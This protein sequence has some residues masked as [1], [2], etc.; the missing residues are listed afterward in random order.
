L[1]GEHEVSA[2]THGALDIT[3]REAVHRILA[4]VKPE[5]IFNCAVLQ[6]DDCERDAAKAEAVNTRG[7]QHLAE[8]AKIIGAGMVHFSTQYAF[9]GEPARREPYT[10]QDEPR[11]INVY[12]KTKVAGEKAVLAACPQ[13]YIVRTSWVYGSGKNSFLCSVHDD[14]KAGRKVRA[15]DDIWSSTTYVEDLIDR[16]LEIIR[17][18]RYGTYHV[19]NEGVCTYY[20]FA[21]DAG[22]LAGLSR[23]QVDSLIEITHEREMRRIAA[24]P[25]YTPMRCLLSEELGLL[26]MR[27]WK[28]ALA[29]YVGEGLE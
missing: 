22:R 21:L 25:R 3:D 8:A 24:R 1:A 7:P 18:K 20:E 4:A 9:A 17:R 28:S 6:V 15:I 23:D 29:G 27:D 10:V 14:L 2:L 5:I 13:S 11:P 12:G 19:V 16:C 26:P